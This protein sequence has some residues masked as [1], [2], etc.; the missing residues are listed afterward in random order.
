LPKVIVLGEYLIIGKCRGFIN[1]FFTKVV[2]LIWMRYQQ[3]SLM[4]FSDSKYKYLLGLIDS[5]GS[6]IV[7]VPLGVTD[8]PQAFDESLSW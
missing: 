8:Y 6:L 1:D 5:W 3:G 7:M 4:I 2:H